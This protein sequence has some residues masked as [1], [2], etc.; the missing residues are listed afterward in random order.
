MAAPPDIRRHVE[1]LLQGG[2]RTDGLHRI[3]LW[4]RSK[5]PR[6][7]AVR[8]VGNFVGHKDSR[9]S[10]IS[11]QRGIDFCHMAGLHLHD[12]TKPE[13]VTVEVYKRA[14]RACYRA[15]GPAAAKNIFNLGYEKLGKRLDRALENIVGI[16]SGRAVIQRAFTADEQR[17]L[18]HYG[19]RIIVRGAMTQEGLMS[20]LCEM[21]TANGVLQ[22]GEEEALNGQSCFICMY[23]ITQMNGAELLEDL[24][25]IAQLS[26]Y[27]DDRIRVQVH[28]RVGRGNMVADIFGTSC[29]PAMWATNQVRNHF[30]GQMPPLELDED[31]RLSFL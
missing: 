13:S 17:I 7:S 8:D 20:E 26:A 4:L 18:T 16:S 10:G 6:N 21:L 25:P 1:R 24:R 22:A 11:W 23:V 9:N 31:G 29:A 14:V 12:R 5:A 3:F 19:S 30:L 2:R 28:Y 15:L 27:A